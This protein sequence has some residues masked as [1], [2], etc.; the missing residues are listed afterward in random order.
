MQS[1]L[2]YYFRDVTMETDF[3]QIGEMTFIQHAGILQQIR[4]S[5]F[6]FRGDK[7]HNFCYILCNFGEDLSTNH[8]DPAGSFCTF[9]DETAKSTYRTKYFSEYWTELHQIFSICCLM[10]ADYKTEIIL[11]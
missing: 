5:E 1:Y 6:R 2:F 11:H 10:Y 7:G 4:I 8:K 3:G 9:W